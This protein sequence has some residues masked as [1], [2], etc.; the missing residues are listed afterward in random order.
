MR[1]ILTRILSTF[2]KPE[3]VKPEPAKRLCLIVFTYDTKGRFTPK[4]KGNMVSEFAWVY[5]GAN[6]HDCLPLFKP[7]GVEIANCVVTNIIVQPIAEVH[8]KA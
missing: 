3:P 7:R 6:T 8:K 4:T 5:D 1:N 2:K